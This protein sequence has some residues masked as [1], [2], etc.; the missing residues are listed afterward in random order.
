MSRHEI[1]VLYCNVRFVAQSWDFDPDVAMPYDMPQY[2]LAMATLRS[3]QITWETAP[4]NDFLI[5]DGQV[6]QYRLIPS[7]P[8]LE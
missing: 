4:F 5:H 8:S 2:A 6:R 7:Y 1:H 3:R